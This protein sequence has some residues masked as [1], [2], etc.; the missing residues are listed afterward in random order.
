MKKERKRV[1]GWRSAKRWT[2]SGYPFL[3]CWVVE[4]DGCHGHAYD[5]V[6]KRQRSDIH[7]DDNNSWEGLSEE[8]KDRLGIELSDKAVK[9]MATEDS[10]DNISGP[11]E[12]GASTD[13]GKAVQKKRKTSWPDENE[14]QIKE[15]RK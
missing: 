2:I 5:M 7:E 6:A 10:E 15:K 14:K 11:D 4:D 8:E 9:R 12:Q 1:L 3:I 13:E